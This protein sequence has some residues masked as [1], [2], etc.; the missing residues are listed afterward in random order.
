MA[1]DASIDHVRKERGLGD[2]FVEEVGDVFLAIGR[3]GF[4]VAR[5]ASERDYHGFAIL[6]G[7]VREQGC[8]TEEGCGRAC[9]GGGA[10]EVAAAQGNRR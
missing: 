4:V 1:E 3:E 6:W 7:R 5:A 2:E 8:G 9:A 10:E